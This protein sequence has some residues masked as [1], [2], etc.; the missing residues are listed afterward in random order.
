M[1]KVDHLSEL[2]KS[3]IQKATDAI[4]DLPAPERGH[5]LPVLRNHGGEPVLEVYWYRQGET[6]VCVA[7][8]GPRGPWFEMSRANLGAHHRLADVLKDRAHYTGEQT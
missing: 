5:Y 8:Y 1:Q 7:D 6:E 4:V 2:V 3:R